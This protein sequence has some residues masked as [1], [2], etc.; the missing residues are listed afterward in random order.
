MQ[1]QK[2]RH[3]LASC[4][5]VCF[6][7]CS[8]LS[9]HFSNEEEYFKKVFDQH[10]LHS[11]L[12]KIP[13]FIASHRQTIMQITSTNSVIPNLLQP[14][15]YKYTTVLANTWKRMTQHPCT[16]MIV[17]GTA[18]TGKSYLINC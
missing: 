3:V 7:G 13:S 12:H 11:N 16:Y 14:N 10:L 4:D 15:H 6:I 2:M 1:T 9:H 18:G 8:Q 17:T 5:G